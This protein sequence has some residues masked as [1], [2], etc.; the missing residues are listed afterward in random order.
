M[1]TTFVID[2]AKLAEVLRSAVGPVARRLLEDG[3]LVKN[4]ARRLVGVHRPL[5]G[6]NRQRRPGQLRDSIVKRLV[7]GGRAGV[8]V[9]VG[10]DDPI[11]LLHHEGTSPHVIEPVRAKVLRFPTGDG[12]VVFA[13]RVNH[14]GTAPNPY[15]IDALKVL[16]GRY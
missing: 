6:E 16:R 7:P 11:A 1:A 15:L 4:E 5:P 12:G 14:P 9:Q 8:V 3:E 10:S 13:L 2:G